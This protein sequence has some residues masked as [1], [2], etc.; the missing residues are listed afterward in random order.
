MKP[1]AALKSAGVIG[2]VRCFAALAWLLVA[3]AAPAAERQWLHGQVPPAAAHL[4]ALGRLSGTNHLDLAIS[5]P[6]RNREAL[7][8]LLE[9]I[10]NPASPNYHRYLTPEQFAEQFGPTEHDYQAAIAFA[11]ARGLT[12]TGLHPNRTLVDV[13]GTVATVERAFHLHMQVYQ[14]PTEARTFYAPDVEPSLDLAVPTLAINGLDDYVLPRPMDFRNGSFGKAA[15]TTNG[16]TPEATA[17]LTGSGPRGNFIGKDFRAAYAPGVSVNGAG[18]TVG[19]LELDGY[20]PTDITAYEKLAALPNVPLTNVLLDGFRGFPGSD[21]REAALD[22]D[23]AICMAPGLSRVIVYEGEASLPND[24]LNRMA[25]DNLARQLSSSWSYG[26]QVDS[27]REQIFQQFAMQGQTMFQASGDLGAWSGPIFP[28]SDDALLTVVGGTSLTTGAGGA[29][30]SETTW[31]ESGGGISTSYPIPVWQ[32]GVSM[33]ANQGS[34]TM[35]NIPDVACLADEVIWLVANNGQ[36]GTVGGTSAAAPL[37]AG[38]A[39]LAN[40]QAAAAGRP[41]VGFLNP[42]LSLIGQGSGYGA[43][44]HDITTGNNTT[45]SSPNLFFAVPGYDLCTGWGTPTGSNLISALVFP[46]DALLITP[47]ASVTAVGPAG[48]PFS[49]ASQNYLLSTFG[50][51]SINWALA[52]TSVWLNVSITNGTVA[53]NTP[54]GTVTVNLNSAASNLAAGSYTATV[55]FTNLNDGFAQSRQFNLDIITPPV[56]TVQPSNQTALPGAVAT[57]TVGTASNALLFYQWREDGT[58]LTDVGNVSGSGT[59]TLALGNVSSAD[60]GNY[61][62]VVSNSL[63]SSTSTVAALTIV[64]VTAPGVTMSTLHSFSGGNDGGNPNGLVETADGN[65]F[66][67]TQNGG[68]NSDGTIFQITPSGSVPVLYSFTGGNDG[69]HPQDALVQGVDGSFYGTTFDGGLYGNGTVFN[70]ASNGFPTT[71]FPFNVTNGDLPFAGLTRGTDGNYYGTTYQGGPSASGT[72]YKMTPAGQLT[73]LYSFTGGLDGGSVYAGLTQGLDGSFYGTTFAGGID[74]A[75]TVFNIT[76]NGVLTSLYAFTGTTGTYPFAGLVQDENGTFYGVGSGGGTHNVGTIFKRVSGGKLTNIYSFT[77]GSDGSQP[78]CGLML[79]GD[80]NLYGTTAY[81]GSYGDGTVF[82]ILRDGTFTN[83][84]QFDGYNGANPSVALTQGADG[85]LYGTTQNGGPGGAGTIFRLSVPGGLQI[86]TQ[87]ADQTIFSGATAVFSVV[88]LGAEPMTYRWAMNGTNLTDGGNVSGSGT[89]VLSISNVSPAN[90]AYYSVTIHNASG[91]AFSD[92]AIL[93]VLVAPPIITTQPA[94]LTVPPGVTATFSV[95]AIGSQP[96]TYQWQMSPTNAAFGGGGIFGAGPVNLVDGGNISGSTTST[97]TIAN[98][99]EA[100]NAVY[101]V[102]VSNPVTSVTSAF[103][104]LSVVPVSAVGTQLATLHTFLG[105]ADGYKPSALTLGTDGNLYGT[106]EF[107]GANHAGSVF[108]VTTGGLVTNV[109]S[110]GGT[111]GFGPSGGVVQGPDGNFYGTTQFGGTNDAGNVFMMTPAQTRYSMNGNGSIVSYLT[112]TLSNLYSFTG[113]SDGDTPVAPLI[114]GSDGYLYGTTQFGGDFGLGNVF[115]ISTNGAI[116]NVYSYTGGVDDSVPTNALMQGADGNFYGVTQFGGTNAFGS[117]FQLTPAGVFSTV[118][119]FTGGADG[120]FPNGPL[121]QG[122]DGSLYG[123]TRHSV[124]RGFEFYGVVFKVATNGAFNL[125]YMLNSNDGHYPAAG[126]IQGSDGI[127]YGTAEFGGTDNNN[128]T[129]FYTTPGGG[130]TA[131]LVNFDGF[132]DGANPETPLVIGADGALYGTTSTGAQFGRGAVYRLAVPMRP[133]L[134][135]GPRTGTNLLFTWN[136]VAG[137]MYQVQSSTNLNFSNWTNSGA[138]FPA[139]GATVTIT[140][141]TITNGQRFYRV[142]IVP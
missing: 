37:W 16:A 74:N 131:T 61:S 4:R 31:P 119:S 117:V 39:A 112:S 56:I 85:Y 60:V 58:N 106:T 140:N 57:F 62:V 2:L 32:Q 79:G 71:L 87:P 103:A 70:A 129:V 88:T 14:H 95:T 142:M 28:P 113:A 121:V 68:L 76:T 110:F 122:L 98:V 38:F 52:S 82:R 136:T 118:Y 19:L 7:T 134:V 25:T 138:A 128:G 67:T 23:M 92:S 15:G 114:R 89:R 133:V 123:T 40:Q 24:I 1:R 97:L 34:T 66:G 6:L 139:P 91:T 13:S 108:M 48:G 53:S 36:Q 124:F 120:K 96:M 21:N 27:T 93:E 65:F 54:A 77:G 22:I 94:D 107:G 42:T 47:S 126:L 72:I 30:L 80:G 90:V 75:G 44:F 104:A 73:T 11:K 64:T 41:P 81:G 115:K 51:A 127:F 137:R 5:L 55:W 43:S 8:N 86:L 3:M 69:G 100:N 111:T 12:V 50:T 26:V 10:Y 130:T 116:T 102:V 35:R 49:P 33:S 59:S 18:Q 109:A 78:A 63:G 46:P 20:Y 125:L 141:S 83:L 84:L 45:S 132:D 17:D 101:S 105:G 29:W 135:P 99:T 9:Q